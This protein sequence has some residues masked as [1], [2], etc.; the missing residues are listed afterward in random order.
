[1]YICKY[2]DIYIY[3]YVIDILS[4]SQGCWHDL[5]TKTRHICGCPYINNYT[6]TTSSFM[7]HLQGRVSPKTNGCG[8]WKWPRTCF[9]WKAS[10]RYD[11]PWKW[12][13]TTLELIPCK[14]MVKFPCV[15]VCVKR[16][17]LCKLHHLPSSWYRANHSHQGDTVSC[18][19]WFSLKSLLET[20]LHLKLCRTSTSRSFNTFISVN[21]QK[22]H[23]KVH[24]TSRQSILRTLRHPAM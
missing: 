13:Y 22:F 8:T 18:L 23:P 15:L 6:T 3:N 7:V 1:M 19:G 11:K 17:L 2:N 20:E 16:L 24:G 21:V 5:L 9:Q 14:Q 12:N 10:T 4:L